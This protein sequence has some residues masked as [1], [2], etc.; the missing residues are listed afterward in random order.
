MIGADGLQYGPITI[1]QLKS[2]IT[3]GRVTAETKILRSDTN[4][5]LP[6][7]YY[8]ELGLMPPAPAPAAAPVVTGA[9]RIPGRSPQ[10]Q[11]Q[12]FAGDPLLERRVKRGASWFYLIAVFSLINHFLMANAG[13]FFLIGLGVN[14]MTSD[15]ILTVIVSAVFG[16]LGYFAGRGH[17]W[18]FIV[19][20]LLYALDALIFVMA[21]D[22]LPLLFHAYGLYR[23]FMGLKATIDLKRGN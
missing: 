12:F 15:L 8:S 23:I 6:A 9:P 18:S 11:Q 5:W 17:A 7:A 10:P 3:E 2:W 22:W 14:L 16:L 21:S 4:S 19:G 1:D 13:G 20:M